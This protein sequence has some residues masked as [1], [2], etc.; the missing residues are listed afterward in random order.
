MDMDVDALPSSSS[1]APTS[2]PKRGRP[3]VRGPQP[4]AAQPPAKASRPGSGASP[5]SGP[6]AG[7]VPPQL[8]GRANVATDDLSA[9]FTNKSQAALRRKAQGD[10]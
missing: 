9:L 5:G 2:G 10:A 1:L 4:S 3:D 7:F 8:R 6:R